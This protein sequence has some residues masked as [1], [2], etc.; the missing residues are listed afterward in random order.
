M[1]RPN[2]TAPA[3]SRR[4]FVGGLAAVLGCVACE[5]GDE[6]EDEAGDT[7]GSAT[8][9]T[10]D[11]ERMHVGRIEGSTATIAV[12]VE[13]DA[14][15]VYVCGTEDTLNTHTRWF[16]GLGLTGGAF[17]GSD[18][19]GWAVEGSIDGASISGTLTDATGAASA[20]SASAV[21]TDPVAGL[22]TAVLDGCETGVVV[23]SATDAQG[24]Y[25][26]TTAEFDQVIILQPVTLTANGGIEGS[27]EGPSGEEPLEFEVLPF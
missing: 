21:D 3:C 1:I 23:Q 2:L 26:S 8:G 10:G 25:C 7:D 27:V 5:P 20:F 15:T 4:R 16:R 22:Y 17:S 14:A 24:A 11:S 13:G 9:G 6:N 19:S 12:V 18:A